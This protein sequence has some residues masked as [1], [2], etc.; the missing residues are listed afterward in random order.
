MVGDRCKDLQAAHCVGVSHLYLV[1]TGLGMEEQHN[2]TS[3]LSHESIVCG[4]LRDTV[5]S[6]AALL[7]FITYTTV[8]E[9][10][11]NTAVLLNLALRRADGGA[12]HAAA[13]RAVH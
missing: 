8:K 10:D 11:S 1:Q 6:L 4:S 9:V 7:A 5:S 3:A 13:R 12:R 2:L